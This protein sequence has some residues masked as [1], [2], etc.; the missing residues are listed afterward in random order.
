MKKTTKKNSTM[1]KLLPAFA[2][3]TVSAISLSSA[4][5]AWFTMSKEVSLT[6]IQMTASVPA[7]LQISLGAG[8]NTSALKTSAGDAA[9][10]TA[11]TRT[12]NV[13]APSTEQDTTE[14]SNSIAV[15]DYYTFGR[16]SPAT[17]INGATIYYTTDSTGVGKTIKDDSN[18]PSSGVSTFAAATA[19]ANRGVADPT[20]TAASA[21]AD[22]TGGAYY[23]DIPVWFRTSVHANSASNINLGVVA[24]FSDPGSSNGTPS[25]IKAARVALLNS[26]GAS[27]GVIMDSDAKYY[28]NKAHTASSATGYAAATTDG[29]DAAYTINGA[30]TSGAN[31]WAKVDPI[32]QATVTDGLMSAGDA[33][34]VVPKAT[35]DAKYGAVAAYTL[36]IWL[37]GEDIDCWNESAGQDWQIDLRFIRNE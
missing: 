22:N 35:G 26:S 5:Y 37:D 33:V 8:T 1:R 11:A 25:I 12:L 15:G 34:V 2:M 24:T 13:G 14:W 28:H 6:G 10:W 19:A 20:K 30:T 23:I 3:L 16:L 7:D 31:T 4:T 36:R 32:V 9:A 27:E 29:D 21:N 17:S 18:S